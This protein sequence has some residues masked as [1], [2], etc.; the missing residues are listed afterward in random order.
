[1]E[2]VIIGSVEV[3]MEALTMRTW[4]PQWCGVGDALGACD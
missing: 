2:A 1:M 3:H 4:R